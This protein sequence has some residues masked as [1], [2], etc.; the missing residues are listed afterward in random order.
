MRVK[1][2]CL[3]RPAEWG[4]DV[5]VGSVHEKR[6]TERR[7]ES[8]KAVID[9][10]R[11]RRQNGADV[12]AV[13]D[14]LIGASRTNP[15]SASR[16]TDC[17]VASNRQVKSTTFDACSTCDAAISTRTAT[18]M[19]SHLP[20][21]PISFLIEQKTLIYRRARHRG[22]DVESVDAETSA[23][24]LH[25]QGPQAV[26]SEWSSRPVAVPGSGV[27]ACTV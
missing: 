6:S 8:S 14:A 17:K 2:L 24:S 11:P 12:E 5:P 21:Y 4:S 19:S 18:H 10:M 1:R 7:Q 27:A 15:N 9:I 13:Q 26:R 16:L 25:L 20:K 3:C 23:C 22:W